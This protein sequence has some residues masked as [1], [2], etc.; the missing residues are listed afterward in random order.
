MQS[1]LDNAS[2]VLEK[3]DGDIIEADAI[4]KELQSKIGYTRKQLKQAERDAEFQVAVVT[5]LKNEVLSLQEQYKALEAS[6]IF[7]VQEQERLAKSVKIKQLRLD[8]LTNEITE[9]SSQLTVIQTETDLVTKS[10]RRSSDTDKT[11]R[12][13]LADKKLRLQ[14][15]AQDLKTRRADIK[16]E[17][18]IQQQINPK[19]PTPR[20]NRLKGY[21]EI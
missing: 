18:I 1:Y 10:L 6:R 7:S 21:Y 11:I 9:K 4:H 12:Q 19:L 16:K 20:K 17:L 2:E 8:T 13:S 5:D 15:E 3:L 14:E